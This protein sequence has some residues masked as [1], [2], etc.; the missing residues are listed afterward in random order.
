[1]Y[2]CILNMYSFFSNSFIYKFGHAKIF[3]FIERKAISCL[4]V[5]FPKSTHIQI[6]YKEGKSKGKRVCQNCKWIQATFSLML[7]Y[8]DFS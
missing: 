7:M 4:S 2:F 1:M 8:I 5:E 3:L 6:S